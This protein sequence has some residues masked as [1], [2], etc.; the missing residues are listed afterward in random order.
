MLVD[1]IGIRGEEV[2]QS[3]FSGR[4]KAVIFQLTIGSK[5]GFEIVMT[6]V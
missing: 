5:R 3:S 6:S 1:T 4:E 2:M